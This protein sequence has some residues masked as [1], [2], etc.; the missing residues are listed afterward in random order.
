MPSSICSVG[1][2]VADESFNVLSR[3]NIW[4]NPKTKYNLNGTRE[5]VGIDL[6]LDKALLDA[7]P[8]FAEVYP[9]LKR[10]LT[11]EGTLV[12]G[13]AVD[14]DVR[15][16]NA[17]CDRYK[18]PGIDFRFVCSQ[19]LYKMYRGDKDVKGLNKIAADIGVEF[20]QHNSEEDAY[21][22]MMTMK[23]LVG[24]SGLSVDELIDKYRIRFGTN[25]NKQLFR[26]VSLLGQVSKKQIT[27]V[28]VQR[29]RDYCATMPKRDN[30]WGNKAFALARS[31]EQSDSHELWAVVTEIASHG[32]K[33]CS[34]LAKCNVY[35]ATDKPTPTDVNRQVHVTQMEEQG[36]LKVVSVADVLNGNV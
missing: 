18:L 31:L 29:I 32:A 11:A 22:S 23:F 1:V 35:V 19:L 15:M 17:A 6:H 5:N 14:A 2:V 25:V 7:S 36:L 33:Y 3:R 8:D 24:D 34:K 27:Q 21:A 16:L 9:E 30:A 20:Q 28:A 10:L 26:P 12:L 4:I 13:H